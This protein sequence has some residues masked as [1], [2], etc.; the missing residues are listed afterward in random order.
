MN[1]AYYF[2]LTFSILQI[3]ERQISD[4]KLQKGIAGAKKRF[5]L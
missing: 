4:K 5:I 1:N 3:W 2:T